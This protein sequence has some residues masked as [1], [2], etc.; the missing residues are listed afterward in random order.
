[1]VSKQNLHRFKN[2]VNDGMTFYI[3]GPN[4]AALKTGSFKLTL[5]DQKSTSVQQ[6]VITECNDFSGSVFG[7]SFVDFQTVLSLTHP[8]D[9][10]VH[11]IGL[12]VTIAEIQ[13]D[14]RRIVGILQFGQ[15]N[16]WRDR[17]NVNTYF[18]SSKLFINYDIDE[19]TNFNK[20]FMIP[21]RVQNNIGTLT[22][23][24]FKRE[25]KYMLK[26]SAKEFVQ[27]MSEHG[28]DVG[29]YPGKINALKCLKFA[30]KIY[31]TKFNVSNKNNQYDIDRISDDKTL[32]EQLENK[33]TESQPSN[34]RS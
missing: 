4:F 34:S 29:F 11:V 13:Q 6:T 1:M 19:I 9:T 21:I 10:Y 16:V 3:R 17:P 27:K 15:I 31:V 33:F 14:N 24:M 20:R 8:Q 22:L 12:V 25:G 32:I 2:V 23:T 7:F 30:F 26:Q 18:T 28:D 5:H